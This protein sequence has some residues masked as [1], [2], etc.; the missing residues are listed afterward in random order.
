MN[1]WIQDFQNKYISY[2]KTALICFVTRKCKCKLSSIKLFCYIITLCTGIVS[3]FVKIQR[4]QNGSTPYC[5]T[6]WRAPKPKTL[7]YTS[8]NMN[9][10]GSYWYM[11]AS[12][13]H[14][15]MFEKIHRLRFLWMHSI[16][17][18]QSM[19]NYKIRILLS[20][21]RQYFF[22]PLIIYF[23]AAG[24]YIWKSHSEWQREILQYEKEGDIYS[25]SN[26]S[27]VKFD[28]LL[29]RKIAFSFP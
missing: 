17:K 22:Q 16:C 3:F 24:S 6:E 9:Y 10:F 7:K 29:P 1:T 15:H 28:S 21:G 18:E 11:Q 20:G 27:G 19:T 2:V 14:I 4:L 13:N 12:L 5:F 26:Q 25:F 23:A 8:T